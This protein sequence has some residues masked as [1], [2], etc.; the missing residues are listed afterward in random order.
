MP[1][2]GVSDGGDAIGLHVAGQ[3]AAP[4]LELAAALRAGGHTHLQ[5]R[6]VGQRH[7]QHGP[8]RG[9]PGRHRQLDDEVAA[10]DVI[11]RVR[12][13]VHLEEEVASRRAAVA[14]GTLPGEPD[15]PARANAGG[16]LHV[17]R[18]RLERHAALRVHARALQRDLPRR[19]AEGVLEVEHDLGVVVLAAPLEASAAMP[20]ARPT[21]RPAPAARRARAHAAEEL[22]EEVAEL[23]GVH[24][25]GAAAGELEARIPVGRRREGL[26]LLAA[27]ADGVVGGAPLGVREHRVGL[28]DLAHARG[29]VGFLADVRVV[30]ARQLP[31]GLLDLFGGGVAR[32]AEQLVIVLELHGN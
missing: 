6:A 12:L 15:Q 14:R 4:H 16:D 32:H 24:A 3:A 11:A 26:A 7:R 25:V 22:A 28:V 13:E 2:P 10:V 20:L 30:L 31:E 17:Q 27:L 18:A 8:E 19:T 9:F 21:A 29:R 5:R 1:S 23:G